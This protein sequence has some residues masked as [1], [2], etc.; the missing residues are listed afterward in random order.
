[1][2]SGMRRFDFDEDFGSDRRGTPGF[3]RAADIEKLRVATEE[4]YGR[5][6]IDGRREAEQEASM[7]LAKAME[8]VAGAAMALLS[9]LDEDTRRFERE[10]A[11][12]AILFARK[13]AGGLVARQPLEPLEDAAAEC[14]RELVG[15]PHVAV[16]LPREHV[17]TAKDMLDRLAA[18]RGYS[19]R[20]V[21]LGEDG[22]R[23]GDFRL[24]WA[25]GGLVRDIGAI[26]T[27]IG[28]A[29]ARHCNSD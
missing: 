16:R 21:V 23:E 8:S 24:E 26:E 29:L 11:D 4:A 5:G 18:E 22:M 15:V 19:G 25:D 28:E 12:L 7:R 14:F 17:D 9:R 27:L 1:M 3:R 10:A 2:T 13:L 6:V 20:L